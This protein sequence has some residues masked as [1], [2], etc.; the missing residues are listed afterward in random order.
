MSLACSNSRKCEPSSLNQKAVES[1]DEKLR[2]A[3]G[4]ICDYRRHT[5]AKVF[6]GFFGDDLFKHVE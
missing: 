2:T 1:L 6:F 3:S 5:C 4:Y